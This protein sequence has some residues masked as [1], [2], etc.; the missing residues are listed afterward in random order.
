MRGLP[1]NAAEAR[2]PKG[3][4]VSPLWQAVISGPNGRSRHAGRVRAGDA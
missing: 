4:E 3:S 1:V 2:P